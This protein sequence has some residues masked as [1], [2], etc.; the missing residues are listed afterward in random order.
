MYF[1]AFS[2]CCQSNYC[3]CSFCCGIGS[4]LFHHNRLCG[5][6]PLEGLHM[7]HWMKNEH[8]R[9]YFMI[10]IGSI[11][12]AAAYPLFLNAHHIA[13]GG[14]TGVTVVLN[15]LIPQLPVGITSLAL[16][17]PLFIMGYRSM[18]KIFAFRSLVATILFSVLID[19]IPLPSVTANPMLASIFGGVLLG[20][21][22]GLILRGGATTGGTDLM[23][24][25]IHKRFPYITVGMLLFGIDC[26]S[27]LLAGLTIQ[28]EYALYAFIS[29]YV[30]SK[31]ID[32]VML[33]LSK[34][35]ACYVISD[36]HEQV[37]QRLLNELER[38]V[39]LLN[40]E[41]GFSGTAKPVLLC[42]LS[43]QEVGRLKNI[44]Q[45]ADPRAFVFISDAYEVL[46]E[47]FRPLKNE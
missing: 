27:V 42:I 30:S 8:M 11:V 25:M 18:G 16:N 45:E 6:L 12:G 14:L 5:I 2:A 40:A 15:Y 9:A 37:K 29:I 24:R 1:T 38:G 41:G 20:I 21:G 36:E 22:L 47:G 10:A 3:T 26:I 19:L 7:Q 32:V 28:I 33:G 13:P 23:A 39:T 43:S 31:V 34:D 46:G 35:K 17:I 44:V 4:F